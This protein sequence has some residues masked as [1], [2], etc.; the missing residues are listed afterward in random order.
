MHDDDTVQVRMSHIRRRN[1]IMA[2]IDDR[3]IAAGFHFVPP[4]PVPLGAGASWVGG[5][6]LGGMANKNRS[7]M[8]RASAG[9]FILMVGF[10]AAV[11]TQ[12][13][14]AIPGT[15]AASALSGE[16]PS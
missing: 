13:T 11:A 7:M 8:L 15:P 4:R 9:L 2:G 6:Q 14:V 5:I 12:P 3:A 16:S 1:M 10:G